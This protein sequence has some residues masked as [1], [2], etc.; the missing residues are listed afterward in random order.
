[1]V[2]H[3]R[4]YATPP[5]TW[6]DFQLRI[7]YLAELG[8]GRLIRRHEQSEDEQFQEAMRRAGM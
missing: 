1:M 2:I 3:D 5:R 6:H 7:L 4:E 8:I